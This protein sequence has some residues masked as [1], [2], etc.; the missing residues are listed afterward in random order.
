MEV[1]QIEETMKESLNIDAQKSSIAMMMQS[2]MKSVDFNDLTE[3]QKP[4]LEALLNDVA[5]QMMADSNESV[6][7]NEWKI[8]MP[9]S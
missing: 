4:Q 1:T 8:S 5:V 2:F 3:K 9:A 6:Y 7:Y